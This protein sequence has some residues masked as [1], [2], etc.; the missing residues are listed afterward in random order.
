MINKP[1]IAFLTALSTVT[2]GF[3]AT[4]AVEVPQAEITRHVIDHVFESIQNQFDGKIKPDQIKVEVLMQPHVNRNFP[5]V[6]QAGDITISTESTLEKIYSS[7]AVIRVRLEA[8]DGE[9]RSAGVPVRLTVVKPVWVVEERVNAG[10]RLSAKSLRLENRDIS[11]TIK[12]SVGSEKDLSGYEAR[13]NLQPGEILDSRKITT[14][15]AVRRNAD[16]RIILSNGQG[17]KIVVPGQALQDGQ[18]G[19]RISVRRNQPNMSSTQK[20]NYS[21]TVV[22]KNRVLVEI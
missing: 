12:T 13:V 3:G 19:E 14:P 22:G 20:K 18:M 11:Q 15:P 4:W 1:L 16:I 21:A 6:Q 10:Q 8:P 7:R 2:G 9:S 17:L 5:D